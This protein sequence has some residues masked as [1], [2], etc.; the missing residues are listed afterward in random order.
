MYYREFT[1]AVAAQV[2]RE[3]LDS[4]EP[5]FAL[6]CVKQFLNNEA[7]YEEIMAEIE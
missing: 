6:E 1:K 2:V 5:W 4:A 3:I 7:T